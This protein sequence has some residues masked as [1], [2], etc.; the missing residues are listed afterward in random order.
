MLWLVSPEI[1]ADLV[2]VTPVPSEDFISLEILEFVT[3]YLQ[4][5]DQ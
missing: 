5:M 4:V 2:Q 3:M 1:A